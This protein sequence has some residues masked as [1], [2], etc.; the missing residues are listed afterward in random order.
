MKL[1]QLQSEFFEWVAG[2]DEIPVAGAALVVEHREPLDPSSR[3][4]I[5][6]E[7]YWLRMRDTLRADFPRVLKAVGDETFDALAAEYIKRH[8]STHFSLA[9]LGHTFAEFIMSHVEPSTAA[10]AALEWARGQ[11]FV[12]P[13]SALADAASLSKINEETFNA[14]CFT[15]APSV[16]LI[17]PGTVIWRKGY[18][19]VQVDVAPD[20]A[21]AL[22]TLLG[23]EAASLSALCEPFT[24]PE[25]AFTAIASWVNEGMIARVELKNDTG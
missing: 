5:Y 3:V 23:E 8:P 14:V 25:A 2:P 16:R 22:K 17:S 6:A 1:S 20:E 11:A 24:T 18:E 4:G 21:E 19:V 10:V 7:M 9:Q 13:D 15:P 12:A